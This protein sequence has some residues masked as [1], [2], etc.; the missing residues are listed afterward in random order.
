MVG[1]DTVTTVIRTDSVGQKDAF[2]IGFNT[3]Y[4]LCE[5]NEAK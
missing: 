1:I 2:C 5:C 3:L 4:N